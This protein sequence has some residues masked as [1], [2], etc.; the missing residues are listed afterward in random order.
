MTFTVFMLLNVELPKLKKI[1][2]YLL[3]QKLVDNVHELYGRYDIIVKIIAKDQGEIEKFIETKIRTVP[4]ISRTETLVVSK[5]IK[6][7][8]K[9]TLTELKE[10]E[11]YLLIVTAYGKTQEVSKKLLDFNEVVR[12]DEIYGQYD[13]LV[14]IKT[15]TSNNL[16]DFIQ[17]N[18]RVNKNIQGTETL[19][20]SDVPS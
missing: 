10:A 15:K 20:V 17:K 4:P 6:E 3:K 13:L 11:S 7:D 19:L 8:Q 16:E 9:R 14:K 5:S 2:N 1:S 12:I 18:I